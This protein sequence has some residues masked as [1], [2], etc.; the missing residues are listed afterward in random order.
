ML[1]DIVTRKI[2]VSKII[3]CHCPSK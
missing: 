3:R 1:N 2:K